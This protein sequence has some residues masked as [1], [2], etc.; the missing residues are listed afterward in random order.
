MVVAKKLKKI[1][2]LSEA[3]TSKSKEVVSKIKETEDIDEILEYTRHEHPEVRL[4]ALQQ[5]CPCH[6]KNN[7][8]EFW[9]R[10]LEMVDDSEMGIKKQ[11][12][13]NLCDGSPKER[14]TDII[15]AIKKLSREDD[16]EIRRICHKVLANYN[17]TG[18]W[19]IL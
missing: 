4:S 16:K 12:L 15:Q 2:K 18:K 13:H 17:K 8:D 11:V 19:N 7:V 3:S 1:N 5:L 10:I 6:V 14:E 9:N